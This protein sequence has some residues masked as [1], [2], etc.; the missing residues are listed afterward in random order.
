MSTF[1]QISSFQQK[2]N[3]KLEI[4]LLNVSANILAG[5]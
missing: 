3:V 5:E 1:S 2:W 4:I